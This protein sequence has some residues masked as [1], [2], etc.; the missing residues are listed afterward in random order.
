[1]S[2]YTRSG[3]ILSIRTSPT[4]SDSFLGFTT[5]LAIARNGPLYQ[6]SLQARQNIS[7]DVHFR[8]DI[9]GS[10]ED[11]KQPVR[12]SY[13]SLRDVPHLLLG[14]LSG[15]ENI[16]VHAFFP[17]LEVALGTSILTNAQLTRWTD[18][19]FYPAIYKHY[20]A[21]FTQ[22]LPCGYQHALATSKANQVEARK[23]RSAS[24]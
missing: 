12:S 15:G 24:Y 19:I 2:V 22:H 10:I 5:S 1:M 4:T 11:S 6:P 20:P 13:S 9:L 14:R 16:A 23:I 17:H 7:N 21:H 3:Q 18:Q 8:L